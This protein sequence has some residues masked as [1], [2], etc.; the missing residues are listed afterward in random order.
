MKA[1]GLRKK[2]PAI[3]WAWEGWWDGCGQRLWARVT[4]HTWVSH[5]PQTRTSKSPCVLRVEVGVPTIRKERYPG[6]IPTIWDHKFSDLRVYPGMRRAL[7]LQQGVPSTSADQVQRGVTPARETQKGEEAPSRC[8]TWVHS[9]HK[10][11][12]ATRWSSWG[13]WEWVMS[14]NSGYRKTTQVVIE[15]R[16]Q[17]A[18]NTDSWDISERKVAFYH[19]GCYAIFKAKL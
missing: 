6:K 16:P 3:K 15:P 11:R 13:E 5:Q 12:G 10:H 4:F 7:G 14:R 19:P 1:R 2:R 18:S 8:C 9:R 17:V